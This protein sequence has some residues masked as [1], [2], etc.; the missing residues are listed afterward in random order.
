MLDEIIPTIKPGRQTRVLA[1]T[2]LVTAA[3]PPVKSKISFQPLLHFLEEKQHEV[4]AIKA[5][6]YRLLIKKISEEL[7]INEDGN[8]DHIPAESA[9]LLELLSSML[10]PLVSK[11]ERL[12]FALATPYKF[13]VFYYSD[14]F[15]QLFMNESETELLLPENLSLQELKNIECSMI[16]DHILHNGSY[17]RSPIVLH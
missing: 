1:A 2:D 7:S 3:L 10:F 8:L 13:Q 15:R 9:T 5:S 11:D 17:S 6:C 16:Y 14:C 4:S 12:T